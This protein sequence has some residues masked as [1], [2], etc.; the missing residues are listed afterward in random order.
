MTTT[1]TKK[2]QWI[3]G[4]SPFFSSYKTTLKTTVKQW[5]KRL[6]YIR[7]DTKTV[8]YNRTAQSKAGNF[9]ILTMSVLTVFC[10]LLAMTTQTCLLSP[11]A[12]ADLVLW[13][14]LSITTQP[15]FFPVAVLLTVLCCFLSITTQLFSFL[16]LCCW[17]C[18]A[19]SVVMLS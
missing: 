14:C 10:S 4:V 11:F 5:K 13:C 18:A 16:Q 12:V 6:G 7:L 19:D 9:P 1:E 3:L 15:V 17:W 2:Q 8:F